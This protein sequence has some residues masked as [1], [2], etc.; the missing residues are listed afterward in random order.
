VEDAEVIFHGC[1]HV[2]EKELVELDKMIN[3]R[4]K[5]ELWVAIAPEVYDR[6]IDIVKKLTKKGVKFVRGTCSVVAPIEKM[7]IRKVATTSAKTYF[8][9]KRKG[10]DTWLVRLREVVAQ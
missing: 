10:V 9:L 1:P 2:S 8:Y 7:G 4:I 6:N 5:R 3:D